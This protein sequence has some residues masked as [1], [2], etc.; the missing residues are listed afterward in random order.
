MHGSMKLLSIWCQRAYMVLRK[1]QCFIR[2]KLLPDAEKQ[3]KLRLICW[4]EEPVPIRRNVLAII[5]WRVS[6]KVE[7]THNL[8]LPTQIAMLVSIVIPLLNT[9]IFQNARYLKH[10]MSNAQIPVNVSI[11][12]TVGMQQLEIWRKSAY[13]STLSKMGQTLG[14]TL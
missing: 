10:P 2:R 3:S 14:G 4:V 13:L 6:A 12:F 9:L 1:N 7:Q 11:I 8:A 5:A